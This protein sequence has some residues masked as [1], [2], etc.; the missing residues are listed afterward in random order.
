MVQYGGR[1]V[2]AIPLTTT[3]NL[4]CLGVGAF[5][6]LWGLIIKIIL[7]PSWFASLAMDEREMT[8]QEES[9]TLNA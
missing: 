3:D 4:I 8:D 2:R 7:P 5:S 9:Q 1:A 6:L